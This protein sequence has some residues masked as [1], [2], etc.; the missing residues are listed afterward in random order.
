MKRARLKGKVHVSCVTLTIR[1][2]T[3]TWFSSLL[4]GRLFEGYLGD[5]DIEVVGK[6]VI[7]RWFVCVSVVFVVRNVVEVLL[8]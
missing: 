4:I 6:K 5:K 7:R 8:Q 1:D 2:T 3:P